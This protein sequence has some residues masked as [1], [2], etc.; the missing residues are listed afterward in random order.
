MADNQSLIV[1]Q[2]GKTGRYGILKRDF[3]EQTPAKYELIR[4]V[5]EAFPDLHV[6]RDLPMS[7]VF[8]TGK[9]FGYLNGAGQEIFQTPLFS[10]KPNITHRPLTVSTFPAF[11]HLLASEAVQVVDFS[12]PY[13]LYGGDGEPLFVANLALY[14]GLPKETGKQEVFAAL[15][16][17]GIIPVKEKRTDFTY[18]DFFSLAYYM[19]NGK[20]NTSLTE[21]QLWEWGMRQGLYVERS[22]HQYVDLYAEF[23]RFFIN[24]LLLYKHAGAQVK[25]KPLSLQTLTEQQENMLLS[26]VQVNGTDYT[27][28]PF[29]LP[30]EWVDQKLQQLIK[31]YNQNA[32]R[33]L[34][35]TI[36]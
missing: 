15:A 16:A 28:L 17:K 33:L 9:Q 21:Q 27:I 10:R 19:Y 36:K 32:Q 34:Q 12:K 24:R 2:D 5:I 25:A 30:R 3:S 1:Y 35:A 6:E 14:L 20:P 22:P 26:Q 31:E 29:P 8:T 11:G 23:N 4:P 13:R 18:S 7:F